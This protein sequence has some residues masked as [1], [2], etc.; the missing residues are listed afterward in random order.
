MTPRTSHPLTLAA[1]ALL[2]AFPLAALA[3]GVP[4]GPTPTEAQSCPT[5]GSDLAGGAIV[6]FKTASL[7]VG[8]VHVNA[9]GAPDGGFGFGPSTLPVSLEAGEPLRTAVASVSQLTVASDRAAAAAPALTQV[10]NGGGPS[11]GFPVALAMPLR[12]PAIVPGAAG[13]T[14]LVAKDDDAVSFWTLRAAIIRPNGTVAFSIQISSLLEF[15]NADAISA[16]SDGAGGLIAAMPYYDSNSTGSKDIAIWRMAASGARPWGNQ[17]Y[18]LVSA[19]GDQTDVHAVPDGAGGALL[20]WTDPRANTRS[21]DIFALRVDSTGTRVYGWNFYGTPVCDALGAQSQ[22]RITPDGTGG[23]WVVWLDQRLGIEG[24]LRYSH[25]LGNGTLAAGFTTD[26]TPLCSA[27]GAQGEAEIAGD[28]AGGC[29]VVW[30]DDRSGNADIYAQHILASGLVAPGWAV[31]GRALTTAAGVQDQPS[32]ASV[33]GGKAVVAWRDARTATPRIYVAGVSDPATTD[34]TPSDGA[35]LRLSAWSVEGHAAEVRVTLPAGAPAVL[36]LLDVGGRVRAS[37]RL[38]GPLH[39][40][41]VSL[42]PAGSLASGVYFA[43][44]RQ[45]GRSAHARL[46]VVR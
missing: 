7:K 17:P 19:S 25:V 3:D 2:L 36:D 9:A 15:F 30:R 46:T 32:I 40:E 11:A 37:T 4:I 24:D 31:D 22:P 18:P 28:G 16:C 33:A 1:A 14:L 35:G 26:G 45:G 41:P 21:T 43:R 10:L 8:A 38:A 13:R 39:D 27:S 34:V 44:L 20:A 42:A 29:F 23:M 6:S 5:V 12:H